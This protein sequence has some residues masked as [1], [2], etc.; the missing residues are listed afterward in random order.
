MF[1]WSI[2]TLGRALTYT[3]RSLFGHEGRD[4]V[5]IEYVDGFKILSKVPKPNVQHIKFANFTDSII[6]DDD[7]PWP[8]HPFKGTCT[9]SQLMQESANVQ[10][11]YF[12]TNI[13]QES[14][15]YHPAALKQYQTDNEDAVNNADR[16]SVRLTLCPKYMKHSGP[17]FMPPGEVVTITIPQSAVGKVWV[18][19]NPHM[20]DIKSINGNPKFSQRLN[21]MQFKNL[22]LSQK[23]N[24]IGS[25]YGASL[26]FSHSMNEAFEMNISGVILAP[27]FKYGVHSDDDWEEIKKYPGPMAILDTGNIFTL[28]PSKYVRNTIRINDVMLWWRSAYQISQTTAQDDYA[29]N[30]RDGR[31]LNPPSFYFDSFVEFGWAFSMIGAN[32]CQ[33]PYDAVSGFIDY[34]AIQDNN[35]GNVHEM[36]HQHQGSWANGV[37]D[38]M[39]NNAINLEIWARTTSSSAQRG[40]HGENLDTWQ[41]YAHPYLEIDYTTNNAG[42]PLYADMT[43]FFGP[44]KFREFVR[45]DQYNTPPEFNRNDPKI[46]RYG[47]NLLRASKIFGRDMRH[48][49]NF[50]G[51]SNMTL[52]NDNNE[53]ITFQILDSMNLPPFHP[54]TTIYGVGYIIDGKRVITCR[55]Y[56]VPGYTWRLDFVKT[57]KQRSDKTKFG[58]FIFAGVISVSGTFTEINKDKGLYDFTPSDDPSIIDECIAL[59]LDRTTGETTKIIC[60]FKQQEILVEYQRYSYLGKKKD[61]FDAYSSIKDMDPIEDLYVTSVNNYAIRDKS[62]WLTIINS[63]FNVEESG[64]YQF[65]I[66]K[67]VSE[68]AIYLSTSQLAFNPI[69]DND[70]LI[71]STKVYKESW[72]GIEHSDSIFLEKG[73]VYYFALVVYAEPNI[74][75]GQAFPGIRK[76]SGNFM[77]IPKQCITK[78]GVP[79]EKIWRAQFA[80]E[81]FQIPFLDTWDGETMLQ[82]SRSNW[83]VYKHPSG[84]SLVGTNIGQ[85]HVDN[86]RS[87]TTVLTDS[88]SSTEFRTKWWAGIGFAEFPH[89]YEI[90]MGKTTEFSSIKIGGTSNTGWFDI[91]STIEIRVG[92]INTSNHNTSQMSLDNDESVAYL[93]RYTT[94][95]PFIELDEPKKGKYLR[96]TF[97]NNTKKWKDNNQGRTSISEIMVGERIPSSKVLPATL[98]SIKYKGIWIPTS[99]G[100]YYNG[101]ALTGVKGSTFEYIT[102]KQAGFFAIVGDLWDGMGTASIYL[103][104][105]KVAT[106]SSD[107]I[108]IGDRRRLDL[109]SRSFRQVLYL[110]KIDKRLSQNHNIKLQVES[111]EITLNG[112]LTDVSSQDD[113]LD[114]IIDLEVQSHNENLD[115]GEIIVQNR[116]QQEFKV[117]TARKSAVTATA[118][119]VIVT[120]T[121]V[122]FAV[123]A[124]KIWNK[125]P[126]DSEIE[127][128]LAL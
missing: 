22:V 121:I 56:Q 90:D 25:P 81:F 87:A 74:M 43:N 126:I 37:H 107:L 116:Y 117:S 8:G 125:S 6:N 52:S 70:N 112:I 108:S 18:T 115:K 119:T 60:Q 55:P 64:N 75:N 58:D 34:D 7:Y 69:V 9:W 63:S 5:L 27:Y 35:W 20:Q 1:V 67:A 19:F 76:N 29:G 54:V 89:I 123:G 98:S 122:L 128:E 65:A 17:I 3:Q 84:D 44:E 31:I 71:F 78:N 124:K 114:S 88:D 72:D 66:L 73:K 100:Y 113:K 36:N 109:A 45:A 104:G 80:P 110:L 41:G 28:I 96:I 11:K 82:A 47:A 59:Y 14:L 106:I 85:G 61:L 15:Y 23:V 42:L 53:S 102:H 30:P 103:D 118:V 120:L 33:Y 99:D 79:Y 83:T 57:M 77:L 38:E 68:A 97:F 93:G 46:G 48:N 95:N 92:D 127:G 49:Y 50:H 86:E 32:Y 26:V 105:S 4:E 51:L 10:E 111:G 24:A 62:G 13:K 39:S 12:S 2:L 94:K 40:L 101:K 16:Y 21:K 91:D